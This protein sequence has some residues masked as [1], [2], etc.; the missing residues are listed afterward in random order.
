MR[1]FLRLVGEHDLQHVH[2]ARWLQCQL[3]SVTLGREDPFRAITSA[4]IKASSEYIEH[5]L[6]QV[7][8][9]IRRR[10]G[11]AHLFVALDES[12]ALGNDDGPDKSKY[13]LPRAD[14]PAYLRRLI[15]AWRGRPGLSLI[16]TGT[17][18]PKDI[19]DVEPLEMEYGKYRWCS[20]T[21]A[22]DSKDSNRRYILRYL[23]P[24]FVR[25]ES[26]Q[27]LIRRLGCWLR[28]RCVDRSTPLTAI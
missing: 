6:G 3:Q 18:L 15:L 1:E 27:G 25:T 5:A 26:G 21:G 16:V 20:A 24:A 12:Q 7:L 11:N 13:G 19:W 14:T 10:L 4:L 9:D 28:G 17:E 8:G 23:P 2:K 22:F